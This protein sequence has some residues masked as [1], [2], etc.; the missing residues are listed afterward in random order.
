MRARRFGSAGLLPALLLTVGAA[1]ASDPALAEALFQEGKRLSAAGKH[2][3][4][5]PKFEASYKADRTL[6]TLLNLADCHERTGRIATA[7]AEWNEAIEKARK[8]GDDRDSYAA[9]RRDELTPRLPKLRVAVTR[10]VPGLD[11]YRGDTRIPRGAYDTPVPVD[12]G[13]HEISVRRGDAVLDRQTVTANEGAVA[14]VT[15]DLAAIDQAHPAATPPPP[16]GSPGTAPPHGDVP[17]PTSSQ[18]TIGFIVG[19]VGLAALATAGV[20]ELVAISHKNKADEPDQ[21]VNKYCSSEGLDSADRADT[22]AELGQ[23]VGLGGLVVTGVGAALVLTAPSA[24]ERE[25][26]RIGVAPWLGPDGGGLS[27][28]GAL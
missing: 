16:A 26:A 9:G 22:F 17:P 24:P 11:V 14:S 19:G 25:R 5:C 13:A 6:G 23:W 3:E 4:A 28:R 8:L 20:F 27:V 15:L 1:R 21:C 2:A 10:P 7:W 12:P 18:K